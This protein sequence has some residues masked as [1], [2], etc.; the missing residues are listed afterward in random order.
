MPETR[1]PEVGIASNRGSAC[2]GEWNLVDVLI[3]RQELEVIE[4]KNIDAYF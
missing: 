3:A 2:Y 4:S 1:H